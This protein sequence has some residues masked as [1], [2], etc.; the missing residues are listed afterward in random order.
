MLT[1]GAVSDPNKESFQHQRESNDFLL[2]GDYNFNGKIDADDAFE[3][4]YGWGL[5]LDVPGFNRY[6]EPGDFNG[7]GSIDEY[8]LFAF[9]QAWHNR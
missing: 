5:T 8:D 1:V 3:F 2:K 7:D 4:A 9:I 6:G